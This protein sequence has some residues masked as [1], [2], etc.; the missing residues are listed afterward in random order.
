MGN[1]RKCPFAQSAAPSPSMYFSILISVYTG[2][3]GEGSLEWRGEWEERERERERDSSVRS[4]FVPLVGLPTSG[5]DFPI[6]PS[7]Q[8]A[9]F[10]SRP[11][12]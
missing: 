2:E 11:L 10:L 3:G 1:G 12:A 8:L 4:L 9:F 5:G 6:S 7:S